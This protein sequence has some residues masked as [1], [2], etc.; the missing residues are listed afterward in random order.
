[1]NLNSTRKHISA[2]TGICFTLLSAG[3]QAA[4]TAQVEA[5]VTIDIPEPTCSIAVPA[6][7]ELG[8]LTPGMTINWLPD[9]LVNVNCDGHPIKHVLYMQSSNK[10]S[11]QNDGIYLK[12]S[13]D[14]ADTGILLKLAGKDG[15]KFT[16]DE[17]NPES[18]ASGTGSSTY[19][20]KIQVQVPDNTKAGEVGGI[21]TFKLHYS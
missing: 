2:L 3:A 18:V 4:T 15:N 16:T 14:N 7:V 8:T 19:P 13:K 12:Q 6:R 9:V 1:M 21:V 20:V 11:G 17:Q 10:L 5:T